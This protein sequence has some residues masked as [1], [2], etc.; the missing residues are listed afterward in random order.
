MTPGLTLA[1]QDQE[2]L[3]I[4]SARLQDAVAQVRDLIWLPKAQRFAAMFNRFKWEAEAEHKRGASLRV[5]AGLSFERVSSAKSH[6]IRY[7]NPRA[8]LS[9]LAIRFEPRS[10]E[11]PGGT[12][13]FLFSGGGAIRLEVECIEATLSDIGGEW[14]AR[15]KPA[16]PIVDQ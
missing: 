16:H 15:G 14:T 13:E 11:D 7:D 4:L 5:R 9:L 3:Q 2:D 12:I 1:A 10:E 8:V 6:K